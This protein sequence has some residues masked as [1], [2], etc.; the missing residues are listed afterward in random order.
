MNY[1]IIILAIIIIILIYILYT[2]FYKAPA[3]I[4][5]A[6][7]NTQLPQIPSNKISSPSSQSYTYSM[8]ISLNALPTST[9]PNY[10]FYMSAGAAN[11]IAIIL[12]FT[13]Q[14][15]QLNIDIGEGSLSSNVFTAGTSNNQVITDNFP[16]QTW[17]YITVSVSNG[18]LIDCYI[19]G[20][21]VKSFYLKG[22]TIKL[23]SS[24]STIN[25][26]ILNASLAGF[27]RLTQPT[28]PQ[29]VW[30]NYLNGSGISSDSSNY[31]LNL[32]LTQNTVPQ[33]TWILF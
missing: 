6:D 14:R 13:P 28:D 18:N 16:L 4:T 20:K 17:V 2:Y 30:N 23:P 11:E 10:I 1:W 29:T 9:S 25:Y 19:N 12:Y 26:G 21:L 33:N 31:G 15:P 32:A 7:M 5:K 24:N 8:W 3:L 27:S 22:T